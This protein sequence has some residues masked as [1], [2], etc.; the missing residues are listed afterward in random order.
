MEPEE[1]LFKIMSDVQIRELIAS[2]STFNEIPLKFEYLGRG[3]EHWAQ[4]AEEREESGGINAKEVEVWKNVE[5]IV[6]REL[7]GIKFLH[8][9]DIG[10]GTGRPAFLLMDILEDMCIEFD[11]IAVDISPSMVEMAERNVK[12][13][14]GVRT[15]SIVVDLENELLP[16]KHWKESTIFLFLGS[17]IVNFSWPEQVMWRIRKTMLGQDV[18]AVSTLV[19]VPKTGK[20]I[21][22]ELSHYRTPESERFVSYII[23]LLNIPHTLEMIWNYEKKRVEVLA[24]V[25]ENVVLDI[26]GHKIPLR[27]G[28][29]IILG[30]SH[31]YP[32]EKV[33]SLLHSMKFLTEHITTTRD[34]RYMLGFYGVENG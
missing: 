20:E 3:A 2:I 34:R 31:R 26:K 17:T 4:V 24:T 19:G 16:F 14:Y 27:R 22:E 12:K 25:T 32:F 7:E 29:K 33:T 5:G 18:L 8:V 30:I 28:E 1:E 10:C 6:R 9:V 13:R 15:D 23:E 21:E 11:Y